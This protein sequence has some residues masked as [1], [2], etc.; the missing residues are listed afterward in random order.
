MTN[1]MVKIN[2]ESNE[3]FNIVHVIDQDELDPTRRLLHSSGNMHFVTYNQDFVSPTL[4]AGWTEFRDFYG[5]TENHQLSWSWEEPPRFDPITKCSTQD[6]SNQ[7]IASDLDG[8]LL[9]SRSA[10]PYYFLV[11]LEAGSVYFTYLVLRRGRAPRHVARVQHVRGEAVAKTFLGADTALG[12]ELVVTASGRVTGL[13]KEAGVLVGVHK[14]EVILKEFGTWGQCNGHELLV[15]LQDMCPLRFILIFFSTM[16]AAYIAWTT[17]SSSPE[18]DVTSQDTENRASSNKDHFNF[19][20]MIQNEFWV[21]VDMASGRY[22]WRNLK[23]RSQ[24]I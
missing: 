19:I 12:T 5:L 13:A 7:T 8:T 22:V 6:R 18:I 15:D 11:A 20:K 4:L 9:V 23:S 16:L 3:M 1:I 17:V 10:F 2:K 14:K 24:G 21:F